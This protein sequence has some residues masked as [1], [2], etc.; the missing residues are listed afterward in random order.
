MDRHAVANVLEEIGALLDLKGENAFKVRAFQNAARTV[1]TLPG[2]LAEAVASGA[3]AKVKGIGPATLEVVR[4]CLATGR[5]SALDTLRSEM[6]AGLAQMLRISGM[7]SAKIRAVREQLGITTLEELDAAARDGRLAALPRFGEKTAAKIL[8]GLEFLQRTVGYRLI[9]RADLQAEALREALAANSGVT[10]V[11]VAGALRRRCEVVRGFEMVAVVAAARSD[12]SPVAGS[13]RADGGPS[14]GAAPA[15]LADAMVR[16][17]AAAAVESAD[18]TGFRV[19]LDDGAS[20]A[21]RCAPPERC[22]HAL[23]WATG[24]DAHLAQLTRHAA[25]RGL[26]LDERGLR[27]AGGEVPC[28]DEESLYAALGLAWIPPE[29]REGGDEVA[30]AA[31]GPLPRL[32]ERRDLLGLLHCHTTYSDGTNSVAELAEACRVLGYAWLGITDHSEAAAYA[33]GLSAERVAQQHAEIDAW[34]RAS[35]NLRIFKGIEADILADGRLDYGPDVLDRFDFVIGS[36][37]SRFDLDERA[38]TDRVLRALE[39][40][41]LTILGHPTGRLLL[42]RDPYPIDMHRVIARAAELGVAIEINADPQRLDLGW[43]LCREA[44]DKGVAIAIGPDAHSLAGLGNV[45]LGVGIARK[46]WLTAEDIV[47][48]K[49]AEEF[50]EY[51]KRRR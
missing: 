9:H 4:E 42:T 43:Q 25:E 47:N 18:A 34:N 38:M 13:A 40:P 28:P 23:A 16:S 20:A 17:G 36:V 29:L 51:A 6:P 8:K 49:D 10:R 21:V 50:S 26:A 39:D 37:H 33:G 27:R 22:G 48:T 19:R 31:A 11:E 3:L 5:S 15:A 46:G 1:E 44:R 41:H 32:V 45:D 2:D 30:R 12:G 35:P 24:S 7:G 14:R